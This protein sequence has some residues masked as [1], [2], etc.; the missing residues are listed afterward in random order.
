MPCFARLRQRVIDEAGGVGACGAGDDGRAGALAPDA[1]LI[2]GGGAERVAGGEH[3]LLAVAVKLC[4]E[5]ADG[6][7]LAGAVD[8]DNE[9][10]VRLVCADR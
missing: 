4:G 2:D 3:H 5:L 10:D 6:R 8:A 1:E 7:R 9:N